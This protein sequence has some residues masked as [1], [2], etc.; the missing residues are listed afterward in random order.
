MSQ[1]EDRGRRTSKNLTECLEKKV[2]N[3]REAWPPTDRGEAG[4]RKRAGDTVL[5][6]PGLTDP[7]RSVQ[8]SLNPSCLSL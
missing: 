1:E 2:N 5:L 4:A 6:G 7:G 3:R 8:V